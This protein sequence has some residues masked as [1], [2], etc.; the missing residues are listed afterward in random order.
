M[1]VDGS[2][3]L[4]SAVSTTTPREMC[5]G[6]FSWHNFAR[7]MPTLLLVG[8]AFDVKSTAIILIQILAGSSDFGDGIGAGS[9]SYNDGG[10]SHLS[11]REAH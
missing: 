1:K 3:K 4:L 11:G 9:K 6:Q 5:E 8:N 2:P 7:K 10:Q